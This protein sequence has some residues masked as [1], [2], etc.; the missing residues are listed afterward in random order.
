M[1]VKQGSELL[2]RF[3]Q[4][5]FECDLER[6]LKLKEDRIA[7]LELSILELVQNRKIEGEDQSREL[8]EILKK[9][10]AERE[11]RQFV[12]SRKSASRR[13]QKI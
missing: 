5:E 7:A 9:E 2:T 6:A 8:L 12:T 10:L 4:R 1:K 11:G 13:V 3:S